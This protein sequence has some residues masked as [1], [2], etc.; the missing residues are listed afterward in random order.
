[1]RKNIYRLILLACLGS[2]LTGCGKEA[3]GGGDSGFLTK[4]NEIV[5][6]KPAD[7]DKTIITIGKYLAFNEEPI[8]TFIEKEFPEVDVVFVETGAGTEQIAYMAM[9]GEAGRLPDLM[10]AS[11]TAP[12]NDFLYDLSA[13]NFIS[14]Y[15]LSAL[16]NISAGGKIYQIPLTNTVFGIAYNKT[17]FME[18]GWEVPETLDEFYQLC[19]TISAGGRRPFAASY[20]YYRPIESI[21]FGLSFDHMFSSME[22]QSQYNAFLCGEVSSKNLLDPMFTTLRGLYERDI[23]RKEDFS[24][25]ATE[26]RQQMYAGEVAMLPGNLD[27]LSLYKQEKPDCEVDIMGFPTNTPGERWLHMIYGNKLSVSKASMENQEKKTILLNILDRLS[28]N[29]GHEA[30]LQAFSGISSLTSYQENMSFGFDEV[31]VCLDQGRIFFADYYA[32]NELVPVFEQWITGEITMDEMIK[33]SD[34]ADPM[35]EIGLTKLP[36]IGKAEKDFTVLETSLFMADVMQEVT[37]AKIAVILNNYYYKGNCARIYKGD[38]VLPERFGPKNISGQ[39]YLTIYEIT[40]ANLKKLME[41]PVVNEKE[42][43]A[44]YA[45]AGLSM[46]YAPWAAMDSNVLSLTLADGAEMKDDHIYSVAAWAGSIDERYISGTGR[47]F[48]ELGTCREVMEGA[49][50]RSGTIAPAEDKRITLKWDQ[51]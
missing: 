20:K 16:N 13:E 42:I 19:D 9:E 25:S 40:G 43:N 24:A 1:M 37:G 4:A 48:P 46:E 44:M 29:E 36:P 12:E 47:E 23:I 39:D 33:A 32:S 41:H 3:S 17:L 51:D 26:R 5:T 28:T 15:N 22:G 50:R 6:Y 35:N 7:T 27:V 2:V 34:D 14:R 45:F 10:F 8:E 38:I 30:M 49:V 11:R 31:D 18:Q 21:G